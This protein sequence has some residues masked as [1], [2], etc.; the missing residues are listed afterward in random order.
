MPATLATK[1][2]GKLIAYLDGSTQFK[3]TP[4]EI[5][6]AYMP[7]SANNCIVDV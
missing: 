3:S 5:L 4:A 2:A 7:F 6:C 1:L